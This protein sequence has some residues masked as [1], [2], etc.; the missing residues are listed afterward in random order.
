MSDAKLG[1]WTDGLIGV[2]TMYNFS[3]SLVAGHL[4]ESR[5]KML[6]PQMTAT[7]GRTCDFISTLSGLR[8]EVK[9]ESRSIFETPN[10]AI[11]LSSSAGRK[12]ALHNAFAHSDIIVYQ[13]ASGQLFAYDVKKLFYWIRKHKQNYRTVTIPNTTY[14]STVLL[15]PR[16]HLEFLRTEV[17]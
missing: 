2:P 13:F 1:N 14:K 10:V 5:F 11:E 16:K 17:I 12:G 9:T 8:Y 15:V 6:Y 4:G 3:K 7:D